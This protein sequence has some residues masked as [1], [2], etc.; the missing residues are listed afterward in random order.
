MLGS[1]LA[2]AAGG[3]RFVFDDFVFDIVGAFYFTHKLSVGR[4]D[5]EVRFVSV[6]LVVEDLK[7]AARGFE[8]F[9]NAAVLFQND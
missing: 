6:V 2:P 7:L 3:V 1:I 5:H 4:F 8:P 9:Q